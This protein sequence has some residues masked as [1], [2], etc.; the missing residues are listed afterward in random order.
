MIEPL[1]YGHST[2]LSPFAVVVAA[3][4]WTWLW[5][6][7]GLI[8]STPVTLCLVV[9]ARHVKRLEFL[10]VMLGDRPAL[11][12]VES[13]YQRMLAGDPD[14]AQ[15]QAETLL[16]EQSLSSY[17]DD[18]ALKGL[19]LAANDLHRGVL[20]ETQIERVKEAITQLAE[21]LDKH[22]DSN[23]PLKPVEPGGLLSSPTP[24]KEAAGA[25]LPV[26][27]QAPP[28][29][30]LPPPWQLPTAIMCLAG[31]GPLDEAASNLLAQLLRKHGLGRAGRRLRGSVSRARQLAGRGQRRDGVHQLSRYQRQPVPPALSAGNGCT[32]GF[33]VSRS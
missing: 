33:R 31:R 27:G 30:D 22:P 5:G 10:D 21:D 12:P 9:M 8:L 28:E 13:F 1:L 20:S 11:T 16:K 4:F 18:V 24:A 2:G 7:I 14:E 15:E 23:Q 26:L 29:S 25:P 3:T 17:Y 6:P 32:G 19:Q